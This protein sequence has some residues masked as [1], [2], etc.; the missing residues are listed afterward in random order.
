MFQ[1]CSQ[2]LL[3]YKLISP[4]FWVSDTAVL[5][6]DILNNFLSDIDHANLEII[7]WEQES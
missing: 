3:K 5:K 7:L 2:Y 4:I 1:N 6:I